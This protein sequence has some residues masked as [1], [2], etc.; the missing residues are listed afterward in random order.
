MI[1][2]NI[3]IQLEVDD[4]VDVN[5][6]LA[7]CTGKIILTLFINRCLRFVNIWMYVEL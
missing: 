7:L 4:T 1:C 6:N 3:L 5:F 2:T